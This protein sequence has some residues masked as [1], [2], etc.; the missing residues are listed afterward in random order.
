MQLPEIIH[1]SLDRLDTELLVELQ[2]AIASQKAS[3]TE[4]LGA[5]EVTLAALE[6]ELWSRGYGPRQ[7]KP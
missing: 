1:N 5:L 3:T 2:A 7:P 4:E 6:T